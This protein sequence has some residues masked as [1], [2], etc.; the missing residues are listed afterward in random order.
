MWHVDPLL[1]NDRKRELNNGH[2]EATAHKQQQGNVFS[3]WSM[4]MAA[5]AAVGYSNRGMVF[6]AVHTEM[7]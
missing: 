6:C 4:P 7:L 1:G 2:Y 5:H 3:A